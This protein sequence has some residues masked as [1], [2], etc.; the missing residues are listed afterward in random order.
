M[1]IK[2]LLAWVYIPAYFRKAKLHELF[3]ITS[4]V[5]GS[6]KVRFSYS[7]SLDD[8]LLKYAIFTKTEAE[9]IL[10]GNYDVGLVQEE[11]FNKAFSLGVQFRKDLNIHS[12]RDF[13]SGS[14][15]IYKAL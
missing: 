10:N 5:F 4:E 1:S 7:D 9:R 6:D 3:K 14:R 2:L 13:R 11:L 15:L 8:L 12:A